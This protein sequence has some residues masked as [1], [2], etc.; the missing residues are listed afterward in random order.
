MKKILNSNIIIFYL[1]SFRLKGEN[2]YDDLKPKD[3]IISSRK[4]S[5]VN[6]RKFSNLSNTRK[7][8]EITALDAK[9][10]LKKTTKTLKEL[11]G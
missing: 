6:S 5:D 7:L 1:F 2:N 10:E 3:G 4:D 8:S 11:L 9:V